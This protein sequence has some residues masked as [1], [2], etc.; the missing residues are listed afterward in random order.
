VHARGSHTVRR[1]RGKRGVRVRG[2]DL[3]STGDS[4]NGMLR[5][6]TTNCPQRTAQEGL[7]PLLLWSSAS[8]AR[9]YHRVCARP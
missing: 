9:H 6:R 8:G 2:Y 1:Q 3:M 4:G 7:L 5:Q